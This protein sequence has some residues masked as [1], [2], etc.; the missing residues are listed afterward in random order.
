MSILEK[1]A[2][3]QGRKDEAPNIELAIEL[4]SVSH[5]NK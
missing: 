2:Y 1:I 5:F 3:F 4:I